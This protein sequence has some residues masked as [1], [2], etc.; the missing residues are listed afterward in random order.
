MFSCEFCE[1]SI[2]T[3]STEHLRTTAS[4]IRERRK[5]NKVVVLTND[6]S[7]VFL[8]QKPQK[9]QVENVTVKKL[10]VRFW[11]VNCN[12]KVN[13]Y[14]ASADLLF[15]IKNNMGWLL[16]RGFVDLL[17]ARSLHIIS[18]SHSNMYLLI[19]DITNPYNCLLKN[20]NFSIKKKKQ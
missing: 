20:A 13:R 3:F 16:L 1:I 2:N 10:V 18:T 5:T 12:H 14:W 9:S 19:K 8:I 11:T 4:V 17:I 6:F 15:L 7:P